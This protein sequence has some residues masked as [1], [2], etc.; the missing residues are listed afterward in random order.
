MA[1][2]RVIVVGA[3]P[4]GVRAAEILVAAGLHPTVIDEG[5]APGGQ[6]YRRQPS[7][8]SRGYRELYGHEAGKAEAIHGTADRLFGAIDYR[9]ET[10]AWNV[11][12]GTLHTITGTTASA[13]PFDALII[14][15]GATD[16]LMPVPGWTRP[17]VYTLGAAQIA[18]KAQACAIGSR[19]VFMGTGPLLYLVAYQYAKAGATVAAVLDTS[20]FRRRLAAATDL[21]TR[22]DTLAKGLLYTAALKRRG[23]PMLS[24][25]TPLS[26]DGTA[27]Q[28]VSAV[29]IRDP[30]GRERV[31]AADAVGLGYHL[32]S[33][34]QLADLARCSFAF[35][36]LTRQWLP[37]IDDYGRSSIPGVYLAG[38]GVRVFGADAAEISGALAAYAALGDLGHK[39]TPA[40]VGRLLRGQKRMDRFRRGLVKAFPWP[41]HLAAALPDDTLVCRCE[42]VTAGELRR[43]AQEL[44]APEV[45]RAK[46]FSRCG[47][48]R[49]Q[50]RYCGQAV[51]EIVASALDVP[52]ER[53]GRLRGQAP[54]KPFPIAADLELV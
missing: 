40:D 46:A 9:P 18:L 42:T 10:L 15:S 2:P 35:E 8:F 23:I 6:I 44:G 13:L 39:A 27:E 43:S 33:E 34:T 24:G 41:S 38:D 14:A 37:E 36:P 26:I 29:R 53:V 4:A 3:G 7:N 21:A 20:P 11:Y 47:M 25:I 16:R 1:A 5:A 32:R 30:G 45:N 22:P 52:V 49:C 31:F 28:G 48:G 51:A 54:V 50:G 12:E 19:V 17:G